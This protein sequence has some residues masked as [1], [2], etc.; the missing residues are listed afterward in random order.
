[1]SEMYLAIAED[2]WPE[3]L[4]CY[5]MHEDK[6]PV[7]LLEITE[8][9]IYAYPYEGFKSTLSTK[10]QRMLK[11]DYNEAKKRD[12]VVVF[13]RDNERREL[14]S[15]QIPKRQQRERIRRPGGGRKLVEVKDP[16]IMTTLEK[17]LENEVAGNPMSEQKWVRSST[18]NL[19][20]KL[21]EEGYQVSPVTISRLLKKMG[22]SIK[23]NKK[24]QIKSN[25]PDRDQQFRYIASQR[26]IF[27]EAG[28]PIISVDSKKNELIG[29]FSNKGKTWSKKSEEVNQNDYP[30]EAS[31]RAIP[32]GIYDVTKNVGYVFVG[33]S[34]DTPAFAA[35]AINTWWER[36]GCSEYSREKSL[37]IFADGG[38]S[39]GWRVRAWKK[40]VQEKISDQFGL[41]VTICHYPPGCSKWNPIEH[42]LFSYISLNWVGIPLRTLEIM[43]GY[44]RGTTTETGLTVK[45]FLQEDIY[46]KG[47]S[48]TT[49]EM[50]TLNLQPHP[51]LPD[52]NYT[53]SP[54]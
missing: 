41:T 45:A 2:T 31:C 7:M 29:N 42:R 32:Y 38:G 23:A 36:E 18:R 4:K 21:K 17:M 37:L 51:T 9:K 15:V 33:T 54:R 25:C 40:N 30:S 22:F 10:S 8:N 48:V 5:K 28:L 46:E 19:S 27:S 49:K 1:M 52:W 50:E 24:K 39:N 34:N 14:V 13:V 6:R 3:V 47:Q 35:D 44:I 16:T 12:K 43:L 11:K 26:Q 20:K 53:I